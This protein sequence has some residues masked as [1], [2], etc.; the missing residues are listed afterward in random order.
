MKSRT[1]RLTK[2]DLPFFTFLLAFYLILTALV[3]VLLL[4]RGRRES[5]LAEYEVQKVATALMESRTESEDF[6]SD[7]MDGRIRGFGLYDVGGQPLQRMGSAP[8]ILQIEEELADIATSESEIVQFQKDRKS[9]V[10]IRWIGMMPAMAGMHGRMPRSMQSFMRGYGAQRL[11]FLELDIQT[12]WSN[13]RLLSAATVLTPLMILALTLLVGFLYLKNSQ[14][15]RE[16][17]A[18]QRLAQLGEV[19]R[20]L[21]HEIKNPLSA[22]RIQTGILSKTLPHERQKDLFIIEEEVDRLSHLTDRIGEFL[23]D[24]VG[25]PEIIDIEDFV[26]GLLKRYDE[27]IG[28]IRLDDEGLASHTSSNPEPLL[29]LFDTQR[30]RS[31]LENLIS[32]AL[33]SAENDKTA[34]KVTVR[35]ISNQV[36]IAVLDRGPGLPDDVREKIFDPFFTSKTRGSGVG[37]S[38]SKRFIEAVGGSLDVDNRDGGGT[39]ARLLLNRENL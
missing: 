21:A 20:T 1:K 25:R 29:V 27:A 24:P 12:Y 18:Q 8:L 15:R 16:L 34:V 13:R 23:W 28:Y 36:E 35:G 10:L 22:I 37:L 17:A 26:R 6:D 2:D 11:I 7:T 32:N 39:E 14:Y 38:I 4:G 9:M 31:V 33:Q 30:L 19:S 5:L 3:I